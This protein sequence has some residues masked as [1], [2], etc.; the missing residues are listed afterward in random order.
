MP[1]TLK[2]NYAN[3]YDYGGKRN[4]SAI[5]Y[6]VV[7]YTGND[8][9][10]DEANANYFKRKK[11]KASAHYFVDDDSVTISV[12][13]TNIAYSVGG[14]K[15]KDCKKTGGGKL[16][17]KCTNANSLSIEMCDTKKDGKYNVTEA[18]MQNTAELIRIKMKE[19]NIPIENVIRHFDVNGKHCPAYFC[20]SSA[21]DIAWNN[22]KKRLT[23]PEID[24][25]PVFNASYYSN[26]Y[27]DLKAAFGTDGKLLLNHFKVYGM[28][29]GRQACAGFEV[30]AY[31]AKNPDL[32]KAFGNNL[33]KYYTHYIEF[34]RK[35][36]RIC[37]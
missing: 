2:T 3:P 19:Y 29:E 4:K 28:K 12:A 30:H 7:H 35:E 17:K 24:Y 36:G 5:K 22:F 15:W 25:S 21:N 10:T 18:T 31:K 1:Y 34:G 23:T 13:D 37:L 32:Q 6:I 26:K 16:Y 11:V 9:D 20:C 33:P 27:A 8:G 14:A